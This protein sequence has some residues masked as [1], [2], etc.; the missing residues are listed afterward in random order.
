ML[1]LPNTVI[2]DQGSSD[3]GILA[4]DSEI[5]VIAA[6]FVLRE[7]I[8]AFPNGS[9]RDEYRQWVQKMAEISVRISIVV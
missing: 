4:E 3:E 7:A 6:V 1:I 9:T 2:T 8:Y 5:P